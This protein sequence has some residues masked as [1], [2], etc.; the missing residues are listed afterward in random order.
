[1]GI[2]Q[3]CIALTSILFLLIIACNNSRQSATPKPNDP[4]IMENEQSLTLKIGEVYETTLQSRGAAGL[5][6]LSRCDDESI[7]RIQRKEYRP[8]DPAKQLTNVGGAIPA[9]FEI[10]ALKEGETKIT[11][12]ETRTWDQNFKEIIQKQLTVKVVK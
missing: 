4:Q 3:A 5:Q 8:P 12:Y 1:M 7:V 10:Q 2:K 11:F 9:I 6:L